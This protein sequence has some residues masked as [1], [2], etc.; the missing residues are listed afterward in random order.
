MINLYKEQEFLLGNIR[1][2]IDKYIHDTEA[3]KDKFIVAAYLERLG[4]YNIKI[5]DRHTEILG[6]NNLNINH[7]YLINNILRVKMLFN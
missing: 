2:L 5:E 6:L 7:K 1:G 4:H 3:I